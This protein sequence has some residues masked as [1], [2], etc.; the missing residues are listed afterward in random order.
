[1]IP[2]RLS[3]NFEATSV[4]PVN[5]LATLRTSSIGLPQQGGGSRLIAH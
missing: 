4:F 3:G 1:L 2:K 5:D